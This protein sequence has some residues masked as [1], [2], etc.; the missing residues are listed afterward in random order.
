MPGYRVSVAAINPGSGGSDALARG[1]NL[2][3]ATCVMCHG[4]DL[5]GPQSMGSKQVLRRARD[6]SLASN[7]RYGS[8]DQAMYRTIRYGIPRT[9][10]G[11]Y[12]KVLKP[13]QVWDLVNF[14]KSRWRSD[15]AAPP[16]APLPGLPA[17][18]ALPSGHHA[19]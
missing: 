19:H 11:N 5:K 16:Q 2:Y 6:L 4:T 14:L 12:E 1:Y 15:A 3:M 10:M 13:E 8:T 18:P 9:A 17:T 7:Y